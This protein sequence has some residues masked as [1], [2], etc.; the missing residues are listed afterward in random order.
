MKERL[1]IK[2]FENAREVYASYGVDVDKVTERFLNIPVSIPCWQ[3][4]DI[5]FQNYP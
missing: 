5:I 2:G 3:G 1:I 4:D